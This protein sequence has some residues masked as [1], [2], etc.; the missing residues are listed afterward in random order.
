M[1][2]QKICYRAGDK[3]WDWNWNSRGRVKI[4]LVAWLLTLYRK[5]LQESGAKME[6]GVMEEDKKRRSV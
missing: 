1:P 5:C 3:T 4:Y 6:D 2:E